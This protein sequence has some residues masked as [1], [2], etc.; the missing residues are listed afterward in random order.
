MYSMDR[1]PFYLTGENGR[2]CRT[3]VTSEARGVMM[4][5]DCWELR[6][7]PIGP[8]GNTDGPVEGDILMGRNGRLA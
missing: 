6:R 3:G 4:D 7:H 5:P 1:T 8:V 2:G